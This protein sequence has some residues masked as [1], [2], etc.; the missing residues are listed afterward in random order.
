[1]SMVYL[2]Y[3][4]F[5]ILEINVALINHSWSKAAE[6]NGLI[7]LIRSLLAL[8]WQEWATGSPKFQSN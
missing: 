3:K 6:N 7:A 8:S 2:F 1:M 4:V 5:I